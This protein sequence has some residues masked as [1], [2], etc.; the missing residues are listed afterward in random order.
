MADMTLEQDCEW[1]SMEHW[2]SCRS[3]KVLRCSACKKKNLKWHRVKG[4]WVLFE[5]DGSRLHTCAGYTPPFDALKEL[6]HATIN[7]TR[8]NELEKLYTRMMKAGGLRK[9]INIVTDSQLL[10]LFIRVNREHKLEDRDDIGWGSI[11][12][13]SKHLSQLRTEILRRM[14]KNV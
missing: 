1:D 8:M 2:Y 9:I 6:A 10:D 11:T 5:P 4:Y 14:N 7:V 3:P 13:Y 12:D